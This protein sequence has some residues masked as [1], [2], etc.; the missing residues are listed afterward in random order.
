MLRQS[1]C[2]V[3]IFPPSAEVVGKDEH[4]VWKFGCTATGTK[5]QKEEK[6]KG[7]CQDQVF[8]FVRNG[9]SRRA[10][11]AEDDQNAQCG[12]L[13]SYASFCSILCVLCDLLFK[14]RLIR[15]QQKVAK[16]AKAG[17]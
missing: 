7:S 12:H 1:R 3:G 17:K 9:R 2:G 5:Q 13:K 14:F 6:S 10:A 15:L 4:D 11:K 8:G 16:H